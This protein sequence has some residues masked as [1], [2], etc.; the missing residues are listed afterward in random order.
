METLLWLL[1]PLAAA[2]GWFS[3]RVSQRKSNKPTSE[4]TAHFNQHCIEGLNYLLSEQS[5]KAINLLV[6]MVDVDEDTVETHLILGSLFRRRGEVDR[7]IRVHQNIINRPSLS[8]EQR[9]NALLQLGLDYLKAGLLDRAEDVFTQLASS[10]TSKQEAFG[11]LAAVY[12]Q[13]K[14][15]RKA[16]DAVQQ[17]DDM[18]EGRT[19][20]LAHYHCELA[21]RFVR[22]D[23]PDLAASEARH[24][25]H[26]DP[27]CTRAYI[28]LGDLHLSAGDQSQA[29]MCFASALERN[30]YFSPLVLKHM[31]DYFAENQ[32][33][34][35]MV[36]FVEARADVNAD[37]AARFF[38]VRS[39]SELG[40][41]DRVEA[42]LRNE[43]NRREVSPYIIKS[44]LQMMQEKTDGEVSESFSSL[45]HALSTRLDSYMA[46]QCTQ[47]GFES[48][49]IFWQCP[50]CQ[51]W[52]TVRPYPN[53]QEYSWL[54][55]ENP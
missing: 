47:C 35:E 5:D 49:A 43:L 33:L 38:L 12:E 10:G 26:I 30:H 46:C 13:E 16:I 31:Y 1:L 42:M 18:D 7:A 48:N 19:T 53:P 52:G 24:A 2:S 9:S 51:N 25:L 36:R 34:D 22:E 37:A 50:T 40:Y 41:S 28:Q 54:E 21:E 44:Y 20:R 4:L 6:E 3:A 23:R 39:F 11:Y 17:L 8:P 27:D 32:S 29:L 14:E 15:W 55:S 45:E